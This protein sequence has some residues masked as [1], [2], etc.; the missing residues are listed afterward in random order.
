MKQIFKIQWIVLLIVI[1]FSCR[2]EEFITDTS[3]KLEFSVDTI[4]FDTV[5]TSIG[6]TTKQIRVYNRHKQSIK[7]SSI[8][9][10]GGDASDFRLNINGMPVNSAE[11]IIIPEEDSIYVFVEV[12]V[13][14]NG[15]NL[16][17]V[18]QD[19]VVFVTNT[20]VQ[21]IDLVAW[22]QDA[23]F[24]NGEYVET[25]T[26]IN[27]K[28]YVV[29]NSMAVDSLQTLTIEAGT[30][31]HFHRNSA[32]FVYGTLIVN[33]SM[34]EPVVFQGDRLEEMY[35]DIPGQ[36]G[37]IHI[38]GYYGSKDNVINY[39]EIKNATL[40]ILVDSVFND[41]PTL[42]ISNSKIE[43]MTYAG[44]YAQGA[45]IYAT[46]C[47]IAN[48]GQYAV[49]LV[50]GGSY[51]FYHCTIANYWGFSNRVTPSVVLNNYYIDVNENYQVR[52][53]EKATFGNCIIYG[54]RENELVLDKYPYG[55]EGEFNYLF[56]HCFLRFDLE[57]LDTTDGFFNNIYLNEDPG[58]LSVYDYDYQ[59]DTIDATAKDK[60]SETIIL[61]NMT[62]LQYDI[63]Q[64]NRLNDEGPDPG[65]YELE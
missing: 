49:G 5:F 11:N 33:G 41:N 30:Q 15:L 43:N 62:D 54:N 64:V 22:G 2:K 20:N 60:G 42:K 55:D 21:D 10:A 51:E 65:A 48:C 28:P 37:Y 18:I 24:I 1:L 46:N 13:D 45:E 7:I 40:G 9:L 63:N 25:G 61:S 16:P 38:L 32:L 4:L 52:D 17:L 39:A 29:Y 23:H 8:N 59:L 27:D 14:P 53:L 36:W 19:S 3:A 31:I 44:I 58:F 47:V 26:W 12:T 57:D 50:I 34:D 6:S 56:D 35:D